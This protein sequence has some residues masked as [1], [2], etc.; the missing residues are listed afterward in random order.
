MILTI[1]VAFISLIGLIVLHELGH[2][3]VAKKFGV[4]VEEFGIGYPPK[5]FGKKFG[6]TIYSL[7]LLPFGAFVRMAGETEK[8]EDKRSY[9][10]QSVWKRALVAFAG[11]LSFWIIAAI[12]FSIVF[13]LGTPAVVS[14]D[15]DNLQNPIV[16]VAGV[17]N[18]SPAEKAG[19]KMGDTIL[20]IQ[21]PKSEIQISIDKVKQ[22]Q[23]FTEEY[24]G[25]EITLTIQRGKEVFDTKLTPR[26]SPPSGEGAMGIALVRTA[27]KS[28]PWYLAPWQGIVAT[29]N[30]TGAI[31]QGY[32]SAIANIFKGLPTGVQLTGPVGVF[33]LLTQASQLGISYFLQFIGMI[34]IYIA[35]FNILPIPAVDGGKLLFLGIEIIRRKPISEKIEQNITAVF[36]VL[37]L[38]MMILVT[39][40]DVIRIF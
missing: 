16:E 33:Q 25:Q 27:I 34:A 18:N 1:I 22:V 13:G 29:V 30:M 12:L 14:D 5:L 21:N 40:K 38:I 35:I 17:S 11:V 37:L 24:K 9:S 20:K 19:I 39:I 2:F 26:V 31:L 28:Y 7:N 32:G 3:F 8:I 36:F 10:N 15:A 6:E 23:E 4:K